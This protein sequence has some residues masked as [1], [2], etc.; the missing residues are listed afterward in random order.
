MVSCWISCT[1]V[2]VVSRDSRSTSGDSVISSRE[3]ESAKIREF[4]LKR[5]DDRLNVD[6]KILEE[7]CRYESDISTTPPAKRVVLTFDDGPEPGQTELILDIL[8]KYN[9]YAAFFYD[10]DQNAESS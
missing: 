5:L 8:K 10:W 7:Q 2:Q 9:I 3:E 6:P 4:H 1:D